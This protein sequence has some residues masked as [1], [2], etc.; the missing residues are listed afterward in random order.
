VVQA[1]KYYQLSRFYFQNH[2][3]NCTRSYPY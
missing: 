3:A 2:L 1:A